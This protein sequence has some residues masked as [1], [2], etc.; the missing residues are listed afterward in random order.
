MA[1]KL[2]RRAF[3]GRSLRIAAAV[4]ASL[5]AV[6]AGELGLE[7]LDQHETWAEASRSNADFFDRHAEDL[8]RLELGASFA[9][10][11]WPLD[12][13]G[14]AQ[15]LSGL[16]LAVQALNIRRVRLGLRWNRS[17]DSGGQ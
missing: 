6:E 4:G 5:T 15:A 11:Q 10:E 17:V 13:A 8:A 1:A 7:L 16:S 9:P 14:H 12:K 3:L 2:S